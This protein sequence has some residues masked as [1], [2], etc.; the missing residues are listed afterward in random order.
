VTFL[1]G[2]L[3]SHVLTLAYAVVGFELFVIA[4]VRYRYFATSFVVSVLQVIVGGSLVF[5]SG[6]LRRPLVT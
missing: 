5:A 1:D 6:I 2:S 4:S 3:R